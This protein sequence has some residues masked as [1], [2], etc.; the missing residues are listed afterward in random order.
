[1]A[2][3]T[4]SPVRVWWSRRPGKPADDCIDLPRLG[5]VVSETA[6]TVAENRGTADYSNRSVVPVRGGSQALPNGD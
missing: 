4:S 6:V 5:V 3:A 1:M 2:W